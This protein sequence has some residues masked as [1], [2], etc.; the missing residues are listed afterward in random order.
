[1]LRADCGGKLSGFAAASG[2]FLRSS[3]WLG[4]NAQDFLRGR[5][6]FGLGLRAGELAAAYH[7]KTECVDLLVFA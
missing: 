7:Y 5:A 2:F 1:V 3:S 4:K 6:R